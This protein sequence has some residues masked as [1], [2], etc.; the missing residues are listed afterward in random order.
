MHLPDD[1]LFQINKSTAHREE[2]LRHFR[3]IL[4]VDL[5]SLLVTAL[6]GGALLT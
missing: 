4:F 2:L 6:N 3:D 5:V 1:T